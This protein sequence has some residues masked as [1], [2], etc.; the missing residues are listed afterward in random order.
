MSAEKRLL[1]TLMTNY[2]RVGRP[3][4]PVLN[5]TTATHVVFAL[6]LI[7]MDLDEKHN[8]LT[9]SMWTRL[10]SYGITTTY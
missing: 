9:M 6:G 7:Q 8:I 2:Q 1:N 4:R 3:G 5:I 10:V